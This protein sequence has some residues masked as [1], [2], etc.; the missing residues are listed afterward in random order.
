MLL[1]HLAI[2]KML[3]QILKTPVS[4]EEKTPVLVTEDVTY[5]KMSNKEGGRTSNV[6]RRFN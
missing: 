4:I 5:I 1:K 6:L 2:Y 3:Y